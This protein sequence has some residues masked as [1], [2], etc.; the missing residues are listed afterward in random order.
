[1]RVRAAEPA[2][3]EAISALDARLTARAKPLYWQELLQRYAGGPPDRCF[4]IAETLHGEFIGFAIGEV[5]AWEFG[6]PPC[7]WIFA[8]QVDPTRR[9]QRAGTA[10]F[11]ALRARFHALGVRRLR[12]LVDRKD[13]L[14]L[15]FFRAQ[16]MR[17]GPSLQLELDESESQA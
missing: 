1:M 7:G 14:I 15:S 10:L 3:L 17:A 16:R 5:R 8:I 4:L 12:T 9:L 11:D 6:A 2:D 13:H